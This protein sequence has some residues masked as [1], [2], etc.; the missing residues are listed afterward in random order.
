MLLAMDAVRNPANGRS[1]AGRRSI[2]TLLSAAH[3]R[4]SVLLRRRRLHTFDPNAQARLNADVAACTPVNVLGGTFTDARR[5][6][7]SATA[8]H[9]KTSQFDVTAFI[10][11][12]SSKWFELP[13]GPLGLVLGVE[14]R[15]DNLAYDQDEQVQL[16]YTFYNAIPDFKAPKAEVKEAF[17]EIRIPILKD[18]PAV[19]ELEIDGAARVSDYKLG[20]TGTVWAYNGNAIWSPI[21]GLRLRG[22]VARAVRAPNQSSCSRLWAR[23]SRW[24]PTRATQTTWAPV[25][26]RARPIALL[27]V[28]RQ[29]RGS[30]TRARYRSRVAVTRTWKRRFRTA[31]RSVV[32]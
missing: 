6:T 10:S 28:S 30:P 24:L 18:I 7:C 11:G 4:L 13:G 27:R 32:S 3:L 22:N 25:H 1:F 15:K 2:R 20:T 12:D 14:Y 5:P 21:A 26:R 9:G 16:G 31:S 23:T 8:S 17:G 29:A 19:H